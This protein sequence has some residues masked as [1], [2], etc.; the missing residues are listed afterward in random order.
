MSGT[1]RGAWFT[2]LCV[3][4]FGVF[5]VRNGAASL[6]AGGPPQPVAAAAQA[7]RPAGRTPAALPH[8]AP[9]RIVIASAGVDAPV[10]SV[11]LD[12]DGWVA[13]PP[14]D[15]PRLTGWYRGAVSPGERG[16]AVV[17]GHVDTDA[18][19]A[20]F[21]PLGALGPGTRVEVERTDGRTAVFA[22]YAVEVFPQRGFPAEAVYADGPAP[23]IRLITCGGAYSARDGYQGNVVASGR[24]VAVR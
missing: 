21:Y 19:P 14:P 20:V 4:L 9:S 24:L 5:L 12:A 7:D 2:V 16:T 17:V 23:E 3:L 22:L 1:G 6:P 15:R 10:V 18:G 13:A 11:G 8:A